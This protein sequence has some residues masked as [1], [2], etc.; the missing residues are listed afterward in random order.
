MEYGRRGEGG[1]PPVAE[2][3]IAEKGRVWCDAAAFRGELA[4]EAG[5]VP[6]AQCVGLGSG[7]GIAECLVGAAQPVAGPAHRDRTQDRVAEGFEMAKRG[8]GPGEAERAITRKPF[9][10]RESDGVVVPV[11]EMPRGVVVAGL[12]LPL[13]HHVASKVG[14]PVGPSHGT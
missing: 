12:E 7:V 8:L 10:L 5:L 4:V 13:A 9:K 3:L 6:R 14:A 1:L 11:E 2:R